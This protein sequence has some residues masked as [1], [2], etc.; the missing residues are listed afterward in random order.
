M[1]ISKYKR[2]IIF[3]LRLLNVAGITG[4][5]AFEWY[6]NFANAIP[7]PLS[8]TGNIIIILLYLILIVTFT[9]LNNGYKIGENRITES[10]YYNTISL[11]CINILYFIIICLMYR[12]Y[13]KVMLTPYLKITFIQIIYL[14]FWAIFSNKVYFLIYKA[15]KI[16]Y[17]Y[18]DNVGPALSKM[19]KR[20]DKYN[21]ASIKE[22]YS[23]NNLD[24]ELKKYEAVVLDIKNSNIK[25]LYINTCYV[26]HK[27]LYIVPD[28]TDVLIESSEM[29]NLLDSPIYLL[30]NR[31]ISY[32]QD[33]IKR[34]FD[35]II[36]LIA[37]IVLSPIF[38]I[39][40]IAIKLEDHGPV[41]YT[42]RRLTKNGKVFKIIKFRS[43]I[44]DAEKYSGA[45]RMSSHDNRITHV[46]KVIRAIRVDE[47]PQLLNIIKG[48]MSIVGPRPER[49]EI[50][51]EIYQTVPEFR[52]RLN[53]R[54]GLTGYAQ[55]MGKYNT[56]FEDKLMYD[57]MYLENYSLLFDLKI[58]LLTIKTLFKPDA[59]EG[60]KE[61]E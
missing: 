18:E 57:L 29:V 1:K 16:L 4:L 49:P 23:I 9:Q 12:T 27:R 28:Y 42:Q 40:I 35:L 45:V 34:I 25:D 13:L 61:D 51:E 43:M 22:V 53:G 14:A 39:T 46:G 36:S 15:R 38:I 2:T 55:V 11:I 37:L 3:L 50:A 41:F 56:S 54:A 44:V 17:V 24:D 52:Y 32:E 21:V 8:N 7:N 47:L 20:H 58:M 60:V 31:G 6:H 59:T 19:R 10:F 48:D 5:M 30:K 33:I 26:H